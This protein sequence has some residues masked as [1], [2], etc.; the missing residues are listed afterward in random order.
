MRRAP[1]VSG[2]L[3]AVPRGRADISS[4]DGHLDVNASSAPA[5]LADLTCSILHDELPP[6]DSP[7]DE[8]ELTKVDRVWKA[9][10]FDFTHVLEGA[11]ARGERAFV[12]LD[13]YLP[14]LAARAARRLAGDRAMSGARAWAALLRKELRQLLPLAIALAGLTVWDACDRLLLSP[15]DAAVPIARSWL[16]S[17][18]DSSSEA[19]GMLLFGFFAAYN[20]LPGEHEQRTIELLYTLPIRRRTVF[21][22]KYLAAVALLSVWTVVSAAIPALSFALDPDSFGRQQAAQAHLAR[23]LGLEILMLAMAVAYGMLASFFRG[24]GWVLAAVVGMAVMLAER[25]RPSLQILGF[26][27]LMRVEHDGTTPYPVVA[28]PGRCTPG[29]RCRWRWL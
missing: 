8:R 3:L 9:G 28:S 22:T 14:V 4:R 7:I 15:P 25:I 6:Y 24:L 10:Q 5:P 21:F 20:L 18:K 19:M 16:M 23:Q 17:G 1:A 13:C 2:A 27:S 29:C 12:A 26:A 11:Y